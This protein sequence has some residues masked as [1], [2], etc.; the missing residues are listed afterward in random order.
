[1]VRLLQWIAYHL[2][3]YI[4]ETHVTGLVQLTRELLGFQN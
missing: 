1:M 4:K 3:V 2:I